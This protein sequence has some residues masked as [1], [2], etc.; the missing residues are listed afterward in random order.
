MNAEQ[1][2]LVQSSWEEVQPMAGKLGELFY[3]RVFE[4][5]PAIK[6]LFPDDPRRQGELFM[7]MFGGAVEMLFH[8]DTLEPS[9]HDLGRRHN[10]YGTKPEHYDT[11][12]SALLWTLERVLDEAFTAE[13]R[14]AWEAVFDYLARMMLAAQLADAED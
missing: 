7:A 4:L 8:L 11:F 12:R 14:Q 1:I 5:D 10:A 2:M 3:K 6:E 9:V 13:V